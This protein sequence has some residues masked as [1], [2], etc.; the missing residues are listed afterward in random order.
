MTTKTNITEGTIIN[1][2]DGIDDSTG[3]V[4]AVNDE[5]SVE[6]MF[7]DGFARTA[8]AEEVAEWAAKGFIEA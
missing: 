1:Y 3:R 4:I 6:V 5:G 7:D 2:V 8:Y